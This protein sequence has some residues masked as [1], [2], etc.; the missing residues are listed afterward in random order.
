MRVLDRKLIREL[1]RS[2]EQVLAIMLV[3]AC[4]VAMYVMT[5]S[6]LLSLRDTRDIYYDRYGFADLFVSLKRA[7]LGMAARVEAIEGVNKVFA[8]IRYGV[9]LDIP[10]MV[11]PATGTVLSVPDGYDAPMNRLYLRQGRMLS[12]RES[13]AVLANESFVQAHGLRLGDRVSMLINGKRQLLTIVGV[14]LSPEYVYAMPPGGVMPDDRRF[15]VFWM[16]H[17]ALEAMVDLD[18]AFNDLSVQLSH[19]ANAAEIM[20]KIDVLLSPYGSLTPYDQSDQLSNWF[21]ENE[22]EQLQTMGTLIPAIFLAVAAFLLNVVLSRQIK[23]QRDIIGT[24]KANGYSNRAVG[25]HYLKFILLIV[26]MGSIIGSAV[27]AWMGYGLTKMYTRFFHF[28]ILQYSLDT[29]TLLVGTVFCG[30]AAVL[31]ALSAVRSAV[32]LPPAEAMRPEVPPAYKPLFLERIGLKQLLSQPARII[33]RSLARQPMRVSI[34]CAGISL[35]LGLYIM[36]AFMMDSMDHMMN[37]QF[38]VINREDLSVIFNEPR[39]MRAVDELAHLPGVL[40]VEPLRHLD[41]R[42][43]YKNRHHRTSLS[44]LASGASLQRLVNEELRNVDIPEQ[45]VM[46]S[47]ALA[48]KLGVQVGQ[49]VQI[50]VL[51]ESRPTLHVPVAGI[52]EGFLGTSA[53]IDLFEM[54][55]L[56]DQ[57]PRISG[58]ALLLDEQLSHAFFAD[59]KNIPA[60]IGSTLMAAVWEAFEDTVRENISIMT[61]FNVAFS[62]LIAFGVIYNMVRITFA[63]RARELGTLRVIGMTREEV[64]AILF[65]EIGVV[66]LVALPLGCGLGYLMASGFVTKMETELYR[67]PL[68]I[69]RATYAM[70]IVIVLASTAFSLLMAWIRIIRMD[71]VLALKTGE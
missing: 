70:A 58:A 13:G 54:N 31:G 39:P 47:V 14:V 53:Y 63:E 52:V 20:D 7:P 15:G 29:K 25:A 18:G 38:E 2:W 71:L 60:I 62:G 57:S 21:L 69:D 9:L 43:R 40:R 67:L 44:G 35:A 10:G 68:V 46:M 65:G 1:W 61:F 33:M 12:P 48:K 37:V 28:P 32:T 11:E 8:R 23:T 41:V 34:S 51:N 6:N 16:S 64:A 42:F 27:G 36:S 24:M 26:L 5:T 30:L 19:G 4:G 22:F 56:L 55:A 17:H 45:G 66:V 49:T 59:V 3:M 50:D